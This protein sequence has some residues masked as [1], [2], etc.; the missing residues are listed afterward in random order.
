MNRNSFFRVLACLDLSAEAGRQKLGGIYRFL[1]QGY[2]WDLSLI[3]SQKEFDRTFKD[4]I[5]N[6]PFDG[7][8]IAVPEDSETRQLHV[9]IK[10]PT[11]FIDYPDDRIVR[12]LENCVFVHDDDVDIG[13]CAAQRLLAQ[14]PF[15]SY[16]YAS[17]SD[18]RPWNRKRGEQFAA[19]LAKR[20]IEVSVLENTDTRPVESIVNWLESLQKPIGILA[21][22]DD[23]ARRILDACHSA[24]LRVPSEV[25]ILGIGN[26]ELVCTHA[27]PQISSIIL[28]FEEEGYRAARE[29]QA[30][31]LH[32]R[33]PTRREFRCGC[34]GVA[35]RGSTLG[36]MS[37]ALLVQQ[38]VT[39]I[40]K[41]AF[42]GIAAA[43]VVEQLHVSRRL[44]DLR[45]R[46]VTGTSILAYITD[47]RLKK[48]KQLLD[49]T[50]LRIGEIA[51][52][53]GY[54]AN[55]LKNLFS[56][57]FKCSMRDW[58]KRQT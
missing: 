10:K 38:A 37:A 36:E 52:Q 3:R 43:D 35:A 22:Y 27:S 12:A 15:S 6:A 56:R 14:G 44:A 19:A 42:N 32:K 13:R 9:S 2:T 26:D 48:V 41:N 40:K 33:R 24:G 11:V 47:V 39:F 7:F 30:L 49:T 45:F 23:A 1:S 18:S 46:E 4:R 8:L 17:A 55:S 29:L 58:R 53:C 21:A 28:D 31:L 50:D 5:E 16:V 51:R 54:E 25:S 57:H 34:N 20:K